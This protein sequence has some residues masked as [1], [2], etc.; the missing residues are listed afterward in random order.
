MP[1]PETIAVR[2][3]RAAR[4]GAAAAPP[5]ADLSPADAPLFEALRAWRKEAAAG[6]PAFTI[7][8]DSTLRAI[9]TARPADEERLEAIRGIGPSFIAKYATAVLAIVAGH[10][11]TIAA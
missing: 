6:K 1:D 9:A 3:R 10:G 2:P 5:P 11:E 4:K 7:A 8:H